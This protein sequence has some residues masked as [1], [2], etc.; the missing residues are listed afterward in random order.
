[1]SVTNYT[2][3]LSEIETLHSQIM[4]SISLQYVNYNVS[5]KVFYKLGRFTRSIKTFIF[6]PQASALA[7]ISFWA[8]FVLTYLLL[9]LAVNTVSAYALFGLIILIHTHITFDAVDA[10]IKESVYQ[11]YKLG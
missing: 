7:L 11:Y 9:T 10:L 4:K 8:A 6:T 3:S 2:I 1:M 5:Q